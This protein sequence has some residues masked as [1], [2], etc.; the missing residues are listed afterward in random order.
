MGHEHT[1]VT[2]FD[3]D[4]KTLG[5]ELTGIGDVRSLTFGP[6]DQL[7]VADGKAKQVKIYD[8]SNAKPKLARTFGQPAKP[9]DY[10]PD[11]FYALNGAAMNQQGEIVTIAGLPTGGARIAKFAPGG[12]CLWEQ[13]ALL[14]CDL[15]KYST[16]KP[17]EFI[18]HRFHRILLTDKNAG[19]WEYR[20]TILDSPWP[21]EWQH[22][23]L[24]LAKL[25]KN[26]FFLQCY[27][28]GLQAYRRSGDLFKLV[29][30]VGGVNP[31]PDGLYN[32]R[33]PNEQKQQLGQWTWTDQNGN[34]KPDDNEVAWFKKPGEG[35]YA[36]FGMNTDDQG[37]ILYCC[38]HTRSTWELPMAGLDKNGN[39]TWDWSKAKEI[40]PAD[41]DSPVKFQPL[42][43]IRAE[44]GSI[45]SFGRSG[46]GDKPEEGGWARPGGKTAGYAWM[47]GWAL[48]KYDNAG[49]L[50][51]AAK[52][53]RVCVGMDIIPGNKGVMLGHFEKGEIYHYTPDGLLIGQCQV[54]DAA[55]K[56]SGWM[57]NTSAVAVQRDPKDG[58]LDVFGE[59]SWLNRLIWYRVDDKDVKTISGK[60]KR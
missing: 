36:V 12:K 33:V 55:G 2:V 24:N 15:G 60:I 47:G 43:A 19:T 38:H 59:D 50:L 10:A 11:R 21:V 58:I 54:G 44:D 28:D 37:N 18:T 35:R 17:N 23:V 6:K 14:F 8:T 49:Q 30:M 32:D 31:R 42:M 22:G 26:E 51:W 20:G 13:M 53:P 34:N 4:G 16:R 46:N 1:T 39:P 45:Y 56:T 40:I 52:L 57:D 41:K 25:G 5:I 9:G 7:C 29:A 3:A 27:G 48:M